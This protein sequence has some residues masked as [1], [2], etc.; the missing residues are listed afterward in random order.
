MNHAAD[1]A[2]QSDSFESWPGLFWLPPADD[3]PKQRDM[4][5][6]DDELAGLVEAA[7][8]PADQHEVHTTKSEAASS[9]PGEASVV[10]SQLVKHCAV[11][12][13]AVLWFEGCTTLQHSD[14]RFALP[15]IW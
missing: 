12:W 10:R 6:L 1:E 7:D 11:L 8:M 4:L 9:V 15:C 5:G 3:K 13:C 2:E 14:D